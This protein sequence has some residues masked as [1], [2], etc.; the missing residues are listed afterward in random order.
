[1]AAPST[2]PPPNHDAGSF[3]I[4]KPNT[5]S[6]QTPRKKEWTVDKLEHSLFDLTKEL[7]WNHFKLVNHS[8][9][10]AAS[11]KSPS[12]RHLSSN[13]DLADLK[14]P[15][16]PY[17]GSQ[18]GTMKVQ[19]K[20][21]GK[22]MAR[23]N[24]GKK[25][26]AYEVICIKS[27]KDRV[28]EYKFHHVEISRN[29]LTPNTM[30]KFVPHLRDMK[31]NEE[32]SYTRWIKELEAMDAQSGFNVTSLNRGEKMRKRLREEIAADISLYI[33]R[34][35]VRLGLENC[36]KSTLVRYMATQLEHN[37][38]MTPQQKNSIIN[39]LS[40]DAS[41]PRAT[42]T[43]KMFT[44]AF[45]NLWR[46]TELTLKDVLA[47][48][49][50][51]EAV[52]DNKKLVKDEKPEAKAK[53]A[54]QLLEMVES[55][56]L[57][58]TILGC[59]YCYSHSCEHGEYD[60]ENQR[61]SLGV[62]LIGR[63]GGLMRQN[64]AKS[65]AE[66]KTSAEKSSHC[67]NECYY[68][69]RSGN[70]HAEVE[71]W[72]DDEVA[73]LRGLYAASAASPNLQVSLPCLVST[74]LG[75][76]CWDV[77]RKQQEL[78]LN[79]PES[80]H[81][82]ATPDIDP[83][84]VKALAWYD[85]HRKELKQ[86]WQEH[87]N[88]HEF[89]RREIKDPCNHS[90]PCGKGCPC[91]DA[92][93]LCERFC[94]CTAENCAYK[95]TGCA[96]K[97]DGKTCLQTKKE[98]KPCICVQLNR[99]CDPV[100]CQGCG[101]FD[102]ADPKNARDADLHSWGCQNVALQR[103][104]SKSVLLGESQIEGCG[105]GLFTAEDIPQDDFV[106]EYL[107][108]LI[109]HD[110]GV[111][112]EAR[113]GDVFDDSKHSSYL[114]TL[115]DYEGI[116]VDAAIYGNLSRYINHASEL[117]KVGKKLVN[118]VPQ[119]LFV[120]GDYRIK[121]KALRDIKAGE[122]LF[123]NYGENFPNLTKKLLD[124]KDGEG[125]TK[126]GGGRGRGRG[127]RGRGGRGRGRGGIRFSTETKRAPPIPSFDEPEDES[128]VENM[129]ME[130]QD[131]DDDEEFRP[132]RHYRARRGGTG[133]GG[134][135]GRKRKR[136]PS[137]DPD[138]DTPPPPRSTRGGRVRGRGRGGHRGGGRGGRRKANVDSTTT[139]AAFA[140]DGTDESSSN[141][142]ASLIEAA[143]TMTTHAILGT[144]S[145]RAGRRKRR[146]FTSGD[147]SDADFKTALPR[148]GNNQHSPSL[149]RRTRQVP[150]SDDEMMDY[151]YGENYSAREGTDDLGS[152]PLGRSQRKRKV[153]EGFKEILETPD[154]PLGSEMAQ[155]P[156]TEDGL[157]LDS[158][159]NDGVPCYDD[160][161][162]PSVK[163]ARHA[164]EFH[165]QMRTS[166]LKVAKTG[167]PLPEWLQRRKARSLGGFFVQ[168]K[169]ELQASPRDQS[170]ISR[171]LAQDNY[172]HSTGSEEEGEENVEGDDAVVR[173][174][175]RAEAKLAKR[176]KQTPQNAEQTLKNRRRFDATMRRCLLSA[177][178]NKSP[179]PQWLRQHKAERLGDFFVRLRAELMAPERD[180]VAI[181]RM[182]AEL[183]EPYQ[184]STEQD[185]GADL[186]EL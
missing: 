30:L 92:K 75:R 55:N 64:I 111:R 11:Q 35:I 103:G 133:V 70:S 29:I 175:Q 54:E 14:L 88:A 186:K 74:L 157:A 104:A 62:D 130:E 24:A 61:R 86:D 26:M 167:K 19:L 169:A 122:E 60:R 32:E 184:N 107:G 141:G 153:G 47:H 174:S 171:M 142:T 95:F 182:L 58:Y 9:R 127:G 10:T 73:L 170:K 80:L 121:F 4:S 140:L 17:E 18:E 69:Y 143:P 137:P 72:S 179:L 79:R 135:G 36:S 68:M 164:G 6:V 126:R 150:D 152:S 21:H 1:M 132:G 59:L 3:Q 71:P 28:P 82:L 31:E 51:V 185:D 162:Q 87:L 176:K 27:D 134:R 147:D 156:F 81:K 168:L 91:V 94:R 138:S 46:H 50:T 112:R 123:F 161:Q 115:L 166:L 131:T 39:R 23:A 151:D 99:E 173:K 180:Q 34:W 108:E 144:P 129:H 158:S 177:A 109:S 78:E 83:P 5:P 66:G 67:R 90:G 85:R 163:P 97:A 118:I 149:R 84:K 114:F 53:G 105:Y 8:L 117:D 139:T 65:L 155:S 41:S 136:Q 160:T 89:T 181:S 40:D 13:A 56:L 37:D 172:T 63:F 102:R 52:V 33:D 48:D 25:K 93:L 110:E 145:S 16:L 43:A 57:S 49:E 128:M 165:K 125:R 146:L 120:N 113:R 183:A 7:D 22:E 98:G 154:M 124:S 42:K 12:R 148:S 38:K 159:N 106:I 76:L 44:D 116:W 96:C 20:Q 119:I 77:F 15:V 101:A 178:G 2:T 100:L 45:N